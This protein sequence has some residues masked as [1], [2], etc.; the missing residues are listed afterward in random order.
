M[1]VVAVMR[2][3]L[4]GVHLS[5][6][7][8]HPS[9][10]ASPQQVLA[11]IGGVH[12][13]GRVL[14]LEDAVLRSTTW[15]T[16][17]GRSSPFAQLCATLAVMRKYPYITERPPE[18]IVENFSRVGGWLT[19]CGRRRRWGCGLEWCQQSLAEWADVC[20]CVWCVTLCVV[21]TWWVVCAGEREQAHLRRAREL[22]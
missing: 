11:A 18:N 4:A 15:L 13:G 14:T 9:V 12:R 20:V 7:D 1:A 5:L 17:V 16:W 3:Q 21:A 22:N 10:G 2:R 19:C 6:A 8:E